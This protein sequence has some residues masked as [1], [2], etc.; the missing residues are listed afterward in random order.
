MT[1]IEGEIP[2]VEYIIEGAGDGEKKDPADEGEE[3]PQPIPTTPKLFDDEI[4]EEKEEMR[5]QFKK[6][7]FFIRKW[8]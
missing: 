8:N 6:I 7:H 4:E 2:I 3:E 5:K 1:L